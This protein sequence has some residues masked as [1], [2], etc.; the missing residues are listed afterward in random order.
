MEGRVVDPHGHPVEATV[1]A[2]M[3]GWLRA[4]AVSSRDGRF[5]LG[6]LQPS[7][8]KPTS[9]PFV[10]VASAPGWAYGELRIE[11]GAP[12][13]PVEIRLE[14]GGAIGGIVRDAATGRALGEASILA[15][16]AG[17]AALTFGGRDLD[18]LDGR[19]AT[20]TSRGDGRFDVRSVRGGA[21]DLLATL[22]GYEVAA[23]RGSRCATARPRASRSRFGGAQDFLFASSMPTA[24]S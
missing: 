21:V 20:A 19:R 23:L 17:S 15:I 5:T 22:D 4:E 8:M 2:V 13:E 18:H 9:E 10:V 12:R 16:P 14:A 11:G 7:M 6:P 3:L 1:R 24:R